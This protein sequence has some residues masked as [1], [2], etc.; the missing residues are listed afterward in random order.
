MTE[1]RLAEVRSL[2]VDAT[3]ELCIG[4]ERENFELLLEKLDVRQRLLNEHDALTE[5]LG[6]SAETDGADSDMIVRLRPL[7]EKLQQVDRK[8]VTLFRLKQDE[9]VE[10][11]KQAQNEKLL[12]AYSN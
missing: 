11:L 5:R 10:R 2:L 12:L 4:I 6:V 3:E 7:A 9:V 1:N 8:F